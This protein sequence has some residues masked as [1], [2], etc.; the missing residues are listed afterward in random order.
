MG[1][2]NCRVMHQATIATVAYSPSINQVAGIIFTL[3]LSPIKALAILL[4][5]SDGPTCPPFPAV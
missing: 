2:G 4:T 5:S 1:H 3:Y